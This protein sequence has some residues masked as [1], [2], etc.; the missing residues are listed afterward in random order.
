MKTLITVTNPDLKKLLFSKRCLDLLTSVSE[1]CWAE[2]GK[3]YTDNQM[4]A[5]LPEFDAV[6]TGWGSPKL[7]ADV[8]A[9]PM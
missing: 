9:C 5:D 6:I 1:V 8:L 3:P 7:S 2:E 4:K